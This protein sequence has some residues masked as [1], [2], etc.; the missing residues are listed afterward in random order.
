M[1]FCLVGLSAHPGGKKRER[2]KP[3]QLSQSCRGF[4]I[5]RMHIGCKEI[6]RLKTGYK[7]HYLCWQAKRRPRLMLMWQLH[8]KVALDRMNPEDGGHKPLCGL[9]PSTLSCAGLSVPCT[10]TVASPHPGSWHTSDT[11]PAVTTM[12]VLGF[13]SASPATLPG[14]EDAKLKP[15]LLLFSACVFRLL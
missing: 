7:G 2:Q 11:M 8:R 13:P 15:T 1:G 4:L 3:A 14:T 12:S 5:F 9:S 10:A 6:A